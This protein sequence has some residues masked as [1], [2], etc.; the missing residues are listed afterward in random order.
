MGLHVNDLSTFYFY[1]N[2]DTVFV[3]NTLFHQFTPLYIFNVTAGQQITL[4]ILPSQGYMPPP[5]ADSFFTF[6]VDSVQM[7][8]YDTTVLKTVYT[9]VSPIDSEGHYRFTYGF[10]TSGSYAW[11]LGCVYGGLMPFCLGC[12]YL[13]DD[14][15]QFEAG[16]KCYSDSST[17]IK[18]VSGICGI[19]SEGITNVSSVPVTLC[20][21][22]AN[23]LLNVA[24]PGALYIELTDIAGRRV[25][26]MDGRDNFRLSTALL[27]EGTYL[28]TV[29][30]E[31]ATLTRKVLV[32]HNQ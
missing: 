12:T 15:I 8:T 20:P 16:V 4:P 17:S 21:N 22:P 3:W 29:V 10:D 9:H 5:I 13:A 11:K 1:N 31:H 6:R 26:H 14:A 30:T 27:P 24:C 23:G 25:Q 7:V 18:L 2:P 32:T 28:L 19:P